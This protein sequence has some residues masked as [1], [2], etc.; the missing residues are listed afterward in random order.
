MDTDLFRRDNKKIDETIEERLDKLT[1]KEL[2]DDN[3]HHREEDGMIFDII[4]F[5]D[6]K[7]LL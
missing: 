6:D 3:S 4:Q 7:A 1:D 5:E 2:H